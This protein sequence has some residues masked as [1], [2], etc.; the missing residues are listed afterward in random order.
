LT[1]PHLQEEKHA[2]IGVFETSLTNTDGVFY[3]RSKGLF[4]NSIYF[5][6]AKSN[7]FRIEDAIA[8]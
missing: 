3:R 6:G 4:E 2:F 7:P 1:R 5:S 8:E